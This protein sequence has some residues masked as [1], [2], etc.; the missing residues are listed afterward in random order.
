MAVVLTLVEQPQQ[1]NWDISDYSSV[2]IGRSD[3][4][5]II[6]NQS[7]ISRRHAIIQQEKNQQ[8]YI[9]DV[10]SANGTY[11]NGKRLL[12]QQTLHSGD[13]IKLGKT[14]LKFSNSDDQTLRGDLGSNDDDL[15][16]AVVARQQ[17][18]IVICDIHRFTELSE[19]IGNSSLSAL[20]QRWTRL[21]STIIAQHR[22]QIDKFIGDA[23]LAYWPADPQGSAQLIR[24]LRAMLAM[25]EQTL[26]LGKQAKLPWPL[27]IGGAVNFGETMMGNIG[28]DGS[29][30][31]TIIGD[32]VNV[33]FRLESKTKAGER[34]VILGKSAYDELPQGQQMF[35]PYSFELQGKSEPVK[36]YGSTFKRLAKLLNNLT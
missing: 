9:V 24:P 28:V 13:Q 7:W 19:T 8:Y 36:G 20:L 21:T 29:R 4:N 17:T 34:E 35:T 11:V 27:T 10:G 16:V 2:K 32:A 22:G 14:C 33:A 1:C 3:D 23:V 5:D 6:L 26:Q 15:T 12:T 18:T 25:Y 31:F 30:D